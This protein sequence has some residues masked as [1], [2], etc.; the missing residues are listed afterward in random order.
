[1]IHAGRRAWFMLK[2]AK[3]RGPLQM[4]RNFLMMLQLVARRTRC[5]FLRRLLQVLLLL[6]VYWVH[7]AKAESQMIAHGHEQA[8]VLSPGCPGH[9]HLSDVTQDAAFSLI[10]AQVLS[11]MS[12]LT[13]TCIKT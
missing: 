13:S 2:L 10:T 7:K 9:A 12:C 3:L 4:S 8:K 6:S 1:M 5:A 11:C